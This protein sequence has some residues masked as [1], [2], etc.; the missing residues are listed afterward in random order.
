MDNTQLQ[1][2]IDVLEKQMASLNQSSTI[3]YNVQNAFQGRGFI[4]QNFFVAGYG[5]LGVTGEYNVVI[6]RAKATSIVLVSYVTAVAG[7]TEHYLEATIRESITSPGSY[8]IYVQGL[9]TETFAYVVFL[10][11][12]NYTNL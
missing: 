1:K 10:L 11:D 2:R 5:T 3:T 6:P 7:I 4:N 8:E 12:S 9:A